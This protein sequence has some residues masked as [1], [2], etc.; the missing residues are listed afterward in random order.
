M[1]KNVNTT[2]MLSV[3]MVMSI[4]SAFWILQVT[5]HNVQKNPNQAYFEQLSY[6]GW[7]VAPMPQQP[8]W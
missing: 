8:Q 1:K 7:T 2:V 5:D 3:T 6:G 4:V